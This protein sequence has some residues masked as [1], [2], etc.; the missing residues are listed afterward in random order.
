MLDAAYYLSLPAINIL[1]ITHKGAAV[2]QTLA[3]MN[4]TTCYY[5]HHQQQPNYYCFQ[6]YIVIPYKYREIY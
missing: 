6:N 1:T 5:Y 3:I 4:V 2:M